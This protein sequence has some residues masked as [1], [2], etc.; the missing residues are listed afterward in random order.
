MQVTRPHSSP[1]LFGC[2]DRADDI[3]GEERLLDLADALVIAMSDQSGL[4][5]DEPDQLAAILETAS[6]HV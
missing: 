1:F 4:S 3:S 6:R 5:T 2:C